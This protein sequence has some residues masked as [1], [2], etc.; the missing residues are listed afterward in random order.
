MAEHSGDQQLG[1]SLLR[2]AHSITFAHFCNEACV[3]VVCDRCELVCDRS[4]QGRQNSK[5]SQWKL[6]WQTASRLQRL[7]TINCRLVFI[8]LL[9]NQTGILGEPFPEQLGEYMLQTRLPSCPGEYCIEY[10]PAPG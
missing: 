6:R 3:H 7:V 2:F 5:P 9:C 8:L 4:V 1:T 10:R